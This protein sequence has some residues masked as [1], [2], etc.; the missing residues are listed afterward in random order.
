MKDVI[1]MLLQ[2]Q[3]TLEE[4]R[5]FAKKVECEKIDAAFAERETKIST[6]LEIAGYVPP[7]VEVVEVTE[8]TEEQ[9]K[10]ETVEQ[11]AIVNGLQAY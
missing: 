1:E 7:F 11:T 10:A 9:E 6:L 5:E 8:A 4:D 3:A 2:K